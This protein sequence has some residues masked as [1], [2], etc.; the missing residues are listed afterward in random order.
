MTHPIWRSSFCAL[1]LALVANT[2]LAETGISNLQALFAK[3]SRVS[4]DLNYRG[5]FTYQYANS[6]VLQSFRVSHWVEDEV[7]HERLEYLN[8]P[9]REVVRSGQQL[10]CL[11]PGDQ[12][13]QGR[14]TRM[15]SRLEQLDNFY[16]VKVLYEER[17]AGRTATRL[18]VAPRDNFRHGFLLSVDQ[19]TGLVL[20]SLMVDTGGR[21]LERYQ[22]IELEIL[23]DA[24]RLAQQPPAQRQRQAKAN[25][26]GCNQTE[27]REPDGWVLEWVP[28]GFVFAGQQKIHEVR[29]MLMYTDG[30]TTFSVFIEPTETALPEL[31]GHRGATLALMSR[32][33]KGADLYRVTVVGEIPQITAEQ[34]AQGI[35][36]H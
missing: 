31:V 24:S 32:L 13:L 26:G 1:M 19:D 21:V 17:I 35:R 34:V 22:F 20:S 27:V 10:D 9:E 6:P 15:G 36:A 33:T 4:H 29:D 3:M 18:Q 7:E 30:M 8:G 12:L 11:P 2:A 5:S 23:P 14:L 16:Q 25:L 28:P